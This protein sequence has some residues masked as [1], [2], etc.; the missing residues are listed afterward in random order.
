MNVHL[1]LQLWTLVLVWLMDASSAHVVADDVQAQPRP[2]ASH[3]LRINE[4][5]IEI[6]IGRSADR[7][8]PPR[9]R[10][11]PTLPC[12]NPSR[13]I[14]YHRRG[15]YRLSIKVLGRTDAFSQ[16]DKDND[17]HPH[18]QKVHKVT[19][20]AASHRSPASCRRIP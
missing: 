9:H 7:T 2:G 3:L 14:D 15:R 12:A 6:G 20:T 4:V 13:W 19:P 18:D 8:G 1:P 10:T 16:Q 5:G 11:A 17:D